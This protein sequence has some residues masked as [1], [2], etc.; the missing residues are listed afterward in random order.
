MN[1]GGASKAGASGEKIRAVLHWGESDLFGAAERVALELA[2]AMTQTPQ[3]VTDE[4]FQRTQ[5]HY[6][7][8]EIVEMAAVIALENFRSR[9]NRCGG[10]E[11]HGFYPGLEKLL[12][13]AGLT[14][15][16]PIGDP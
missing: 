14:A 3:R 5:E 1:A 7:D 11:A 4:L 10:V 15:G 6:S 13:A 16:E 9:F 12:A 2:E 8:P